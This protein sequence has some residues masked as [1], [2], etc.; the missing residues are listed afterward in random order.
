MTN[1]LLGKSKTQGPEVN[2]SL[3]EVELLK[4]VFVNIRLVGIIEGTKGKSNVSNPEKG[5][6]TSERAYVTDV[7]TIGKTHEVENL[8]LMSRVLRQCFLSR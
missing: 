6:I 3:M 4:G 2:D 1:A 8:E 5:G 7:C